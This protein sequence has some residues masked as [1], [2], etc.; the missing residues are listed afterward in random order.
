MKGLIFSFFMLINVSVFSQNVKC[1]IV[2]YAKDIDGREYSTYQYVLA[3]YSYSRSM[4]IL[5]TN[6][7]VFMKIHQKIPNLFLMKQEYSD[8]FLLGIEGFNKNSIDELDHKIINSFIYNIVKYRIDSNLPINFYE[9]F[10]ESIKY[11]E[12]ENDI[13]KYFRCK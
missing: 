2:D 12:T 13:C 8:V 4:I 10:T 3:S 11:I 9:N 1:E 6:R 5:V 7:D